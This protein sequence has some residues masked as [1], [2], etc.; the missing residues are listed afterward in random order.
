MSRVPIPTWTFVL[1]VVRMGRRF[2]LV[3]ERKHEAMWYLPAGR[4]EPGETLFDAACR[5][6]LEETGVPIVP[7]GILRMQYTPGA[8]GSARLRA[9]LVAR[10]ASDV[11]PKRV[12]DHHSLR[13]RWVTLEE[14][15]NVPL[16]SE[17]VLRI[18]SFVLSGG[19]VYPAGLIGLEGDAW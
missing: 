16:R 5:E 13:A 1:V 10:P 18:F 12:P 8:D 11:E 15:H 3:Q 17:E 19:P 9:I 6:T 7:E 14:L 2:L 4:V